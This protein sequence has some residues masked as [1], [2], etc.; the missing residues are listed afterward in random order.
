MVKTQIQLPDALY[1]R[2]KRLAERTE[3]SMAEILRRGAEYMVATHPDPGERQ[4]PWQPPA[5]RAVGI[6][7]G[8][9]PEDLR[10]LA[11]EDEG[12]VARRKGTR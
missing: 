3:W 6:R 5:P 8:V 2:V 1:A 12:A 4:G 7:S 10:R 9:R 11:V